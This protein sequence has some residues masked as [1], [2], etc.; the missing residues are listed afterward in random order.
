MIKKKEH[1]VSVDKYLIT[2]S[3]LNSW[4]SI[5]N[6]SEWVREAQSDT[7]CIEDKIQDA[8]KKA[9]DDFITTL[10]RIKTEPNEYM[11]RGIEFE[12]E[13]YK[14]NTCVSPIIEGGAYQIVGVKDKTIDDMN[15]VLYG[16]LDVLKGGIIYDIKRVS[17][18]TPQKYINSYQHGFYFEL[19]DEAYKFVYLCF[20]GNELHT[21][22]YYKDQCVNLE[23]TISNFMK[24][25]KKNNLLDLY[26]EN[27]RSIK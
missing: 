17:K 14:G 5:W 2:P 22:T 11:L 12:N 8:Q 26:K 20:D 24:W 27:W 3:L 7:M 23:A 15:F 13:C 21:E 18:Y 1:S 10:N 9:Y 6:C 16:R 25:L 4:A 19:F